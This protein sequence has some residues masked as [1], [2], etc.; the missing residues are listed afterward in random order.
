MLECVYVLFYY[1][2]VLF[3]GVSWS[4]L[5]LREL[6]LNCRLSPS[7]S[8]FKLLY[9]LTRDARRQGEGRALAYP[10]SGLARESF[11]ALCYVIGLVHSEQ[12]D[13][14]LRSPNLSAFI[15]FACHING[16]DAR[17]EP[18][19]LVLHEELL[20]WLH[21]C[22]APDK[23]QSGDIVTEMW[24][25]A[26][27]KAAYAV[28]LS[29]PWFFFEIMLKSVAQMQQITD[30]KRYRPIDSPGL[31]LDLLSWSFAG[32][33]CTIRASTRGK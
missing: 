7:F 33:F 6:V 16:L 15:K 28:V 22:C 10:A 24:C 25:D 4:S 31:R 14:T 3:T 20:H 26:D 18:P 29:H 30:M 5:Q 19:Q 27:R 21:S 32:I 9:L 12:T 17:Q 2:W 8:P 13:L 1:F 23:K 11:Q